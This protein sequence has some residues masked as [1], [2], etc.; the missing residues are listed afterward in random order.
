MMVRTQIVMQFPPHLYS[1]QQ[2]ECVCFTSSN[3]F[4]QAL[5]STLLCRYLWI[6]MAIGFAGQRLAHLIKIAFSK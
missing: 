4:N 6:K 1:A 2:P 3:N 5:D